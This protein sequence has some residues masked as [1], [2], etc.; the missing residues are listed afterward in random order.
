MERLGLVETFEIDCSVEFGVT[1]RKEG[2]AEREWWVKK[3][4]TVI[5]S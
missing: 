2:G 5:V 1:Q 3:L 4:F